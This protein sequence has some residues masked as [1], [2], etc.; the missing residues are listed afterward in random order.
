MRGLAEYI[1]VARCLATDS[2]SRYTSDMVVRLEHDWERTFHVSHAI[3]STSGTAALHVALGALDL[4]RDSDVV[5]P[6]ITDPGTVMVV[7]MEGLRP[8]FVDSDPRTGLLS[9]ESLEAQLTP[10]TRCVIAVHLFGCPADMDAILEVTR[11]RG[12][13]VIEDCAQAN[14]ALYKGRYVGT[15][16]DA[17]TFSFQALK[18]VHCG[19]GGLTVFTDPQLAE[20]GALFADKGWQRSGP[21][22]GIVQRGLNYRMSALQAAV[23]RARLPRLPS[24]LAKHRA[25]VACLAAALEG[26]GLITPPSAPPGTQPSWWVVPLQTQRLIRPDLHAELSAALQSVGAPVSARYLAKPLH[27]QPFVRQQLGVV[28]AEPCPRALEFL[29]RTLALSIHEGLSDSHM[30]LVADV[31]NR[32]A[33]AHRFHEV[34]HDGIDTRYSHV[35]SR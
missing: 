17:G 18:H 22:R 3:A 27:H 33:T 8:V 9:V 26:N 21:N 1:N 6:S 23:L 20:R 19:E 34:K 11:P 25:L 32:I 14:G 7:L 29:D 24:I 4:P 16:G 10:R 30:R 2:L 28:D 31:V 5:L 35:G 12:I 13:R 15:S